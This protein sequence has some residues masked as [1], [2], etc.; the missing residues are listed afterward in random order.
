VRCRKNRRGGPTVAALI[1]T[2]GLVVEGYRFAVGRTASI[3]ADTPRLGNRSNARG[4]E[5]SDGADG[6]DVPLRMGG[7]GGRMA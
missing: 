7:S 3:V 6:S 4:L 2:P 5:S 1:Q